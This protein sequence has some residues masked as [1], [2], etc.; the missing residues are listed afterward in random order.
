MDLKDIGHSDM[1]G[2]DLSQDREQWRTP[3]KMVM[4]IRVT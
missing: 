3:M 1:D 4:N 2:I